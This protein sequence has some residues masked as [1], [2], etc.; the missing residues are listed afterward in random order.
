V[1]SYKGIY[2][3]APYITKTTE[4]EQ[5]EAIAKI[6]QLEDYLIAF[7]KENIV[8]IRPFRSGIPS[9]TL[10]NVITNCLY[11][12]D[13]LVAAYE[14]SGNVCPDALGKNVS[15]ELQKLSR[16]EI[17]RSCLAIPNWTRFIL[18][19]QQTHLVCGKSLY[20]GVERT[21]IFQFWSFSDKFIARYN[22]FGLFPLELRHVGRRTR[23]ELN[24]EEEA[25]NKI[26][27]EAQLSS[28]IAKE[29][30]S[31]FDSPGLKRNEV[32]KEEE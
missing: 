27:E 11:A 10:V 7:M 12:P 2:G 13:K 9:V 6:T 28:E 23:A 32:A 16:L 25:N 21:S 3:K 14:L 17:K 1:V 19:Q 18:P 5:E 15:K 24:A 20:E 29:Q 4:V 22:T 8:L 31:M 30:I 26:L